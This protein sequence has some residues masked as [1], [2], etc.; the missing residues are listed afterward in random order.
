MTDEMVNLHRLSGKS[1]DADLFFKIIC[2]AIQLLVEPQ[3][4]AL[5]GYGSFEKKIE[6]LAE[7]KG[8]CKRDWQMLAQ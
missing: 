7:R 8:Y 2:F 3:D 4:G 5:A 6:R 1:P